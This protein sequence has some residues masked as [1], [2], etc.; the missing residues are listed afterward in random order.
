MSS[1]SNAQGQYQGQ[2]IDELRGE[3]VILVLPG[4]A[5]LGFIFILI[6]PF[7]PDPLTGGILGI[8]L[9]GLALAVWLF[10]HLSYHLAAWT[11][12][13]ATC[14]FAIMLTWL[15]PLMGLGFLVLPI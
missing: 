1:L 14:G 10:F 8:S 4:L 5:I 15:N 3:M 2:Y 13:A 6:A 9:L 7:F 12:I 11:L